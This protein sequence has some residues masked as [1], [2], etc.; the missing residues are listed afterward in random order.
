M[1]LSA[2]HG[3]MDHTIV[4]TLPYPERAMR[5]IIAHSQP[6]GRTVVVASETGASAPELE[7]VSIV[8]RISDGTT[9]RRAAN[10][11]QSRNAKLKSM[12]ASKAIFDCKASPSASAACPD[13]LLGF[14]GA[15]LKTFRAVGP[16]CIKVLHAVDA[17]P[18]EHNRS[19]R[20]SYSRK[21][22][23][24]ELFPEWMTRRIEREV[25]LA[26]LILVPSNRIESQMLKHG[27]DPRKIALIPYGVDYSKF[28][29]PDSHSR[30]YHGES[31]ECKFLYVGQ[32]S[33]RKNVGGIVSAARS[34]GSSLTIVGTAFD[35]RILADLPENI[36]HI[37]N[38]S[39]DQLREY[40]KSADCLVV[41]SVE[42]ACALVTFEAAA[43]GLWV[44]TT[45]S[46]GAHEV[47]PKDLAVTIPARSDER[48]A[49]EM[50]LIR[51]LTL[52]DR[53]LNREKARLSISSW[54]E[55]A[56]R[57]WAR[58]RYEAALR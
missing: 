34:T 35:K 36:S 24:A 31:H 40:Y 33:Q 37:G 58:I 20:S 26:D 12:Y 10:L 23:R 8:R 16:N 47:L 56:D 50:R 29:L 18:R 51:R 7:S 17:H 21:T 1:S 41:N 5:A 3:S 14:P 25:E 19:L 43:A 48:L 2:Q 53:I 54:D 45:D 28:S 57:V 32:V 42:D 27:A 46:N 22:Y 44:I 15:S 39:H 49:E 13:V 9:L 38:V 30:P 55:Y 4:V 11:L 52:E 6:C